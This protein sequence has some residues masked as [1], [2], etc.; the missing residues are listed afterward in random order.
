MFISFPNSGNTLIHTIV[1]QI[2]VTAGNAPFTIGS[3]KI[4]T[5]GSVHTADTASGV[6]NVTPPFSY[7][8]SSTWGL[9]TVNV[10]S[11]GMSP[12]MIASA[13]LN[14]GCSNLVAGQYT[15]SLSV[16][17]FVTSSSQIIPSQGNSSG[18][19]SRSI[20]L[21]VPSYIMNPS[22]EQAYIS[23]TIKS[24]EYSD[25]YQYLVQNV[26]GGGGNNI[27]ALITNSIS[28]LKIVPCF[29]CI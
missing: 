18:S 26:Q 14:N 27:N 19:L 24:V 15:V 21:N 2:S 4:S 23:Q 12:I 17:N 8:L 5:A 7:G 11:G 9:P 10:P 22:V 3:Y 28:G 6:L 1:S 20:V 13:G 25:F 29:A 16:G